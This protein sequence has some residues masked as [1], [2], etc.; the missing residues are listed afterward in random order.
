M[1]AISLDPIEDAYLD[2]NAIRSG[3][4][5][6]V[7]EKLKNWENEIDW[8][9]QDC[10]CKLVLQHDD[11]AYVQFMVWNNDSTTYDKDQ[12]VSTPLALDIDVGDGSWE[13]SLIQ[14]NTTVEDT[15]NDHVTFIVLPTWKADNLN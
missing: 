1:D 14:K 9:Q 2:L 5:S 7:V 6:G 4:N 10:D 8:S 13:S 11:T 15:K 3:N 12:F